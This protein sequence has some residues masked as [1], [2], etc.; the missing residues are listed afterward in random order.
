[1]S[2]FKAALVLVL[3]F[4]WVLS[5]LAR[6]GSETELPLMEFS[7]AAST[8]TCI[9]NPVTPLCAVETFE[10]CLHRAEWPLCAEVGF[11]PGDLRQFG[12]SE[13]FKLV[14]RPYEVIG[15]RT[16]RVAFVPKSRDGEPSI[17]WRPGDVA[18]RL[19]WH[20]CPPIEKC[21]VETQVHPTKKYGE[22]CRT[23]EFCDRSF[24]P[25]TYIVRRIGHR[26]IMVAD[27]D[28]NRHPDLHRDFWNRK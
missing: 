10:A 20:R 15:T 24:E 8:S 22:G 9:G 6:S 27:Y 21:V 23:F 7:N 4:V 25:H 2:S 18:V 16:V 13:Y 12:P 14:Y 19:N 28:E 5:A 26:W 3:G 17:E 1:M 11:E